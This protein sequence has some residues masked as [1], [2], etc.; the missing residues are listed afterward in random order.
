ML[1]QYT[2]QLE[3]TFTFIPETALDLSKDSGGYAFQIWI[4]NFK[5]NIFIA[6]PIYLD[7][8]EKN[9]FNF[10]QAV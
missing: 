1:F 8:S 5:I 2:Q 9:I 10:S 7:C 3:L 4:G 6:G